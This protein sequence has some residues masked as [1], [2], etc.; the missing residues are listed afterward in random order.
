MNNFKKRG[1]VLTLTPPVAVAA[2]VGYLF[3]SLFGVAIGNVA[4][5]TPG[6]FRV[7]GVCDLP[8]TSA[9]AVT[10]G[11]RLFWDPAAK[12]VNKT[13]ASQQCIGV[14]ASDAANPSATVWVK[15]GA[16]TAV[17]A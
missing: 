4:A 2:G 14:A 7:E 8:K 3:G 5:G 6:E 10:A 11:D 9:L 12:L 17:G 16:Y 1:E 15:L 13:A